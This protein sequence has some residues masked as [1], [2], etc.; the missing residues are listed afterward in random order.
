VSKINKFQQFLVDRIWRKFGT[1][2][3]EFVHLVSSFIN[4][5]KKP[6]AEFVVCVHVFHVFSCFTHWLCVFMSIYYCRLS[7]LGVLFDKQCQW[8]DWL[9]DWQHILSLK[10]WKTTMLW[11]STDS[12][13]KHLVGIYHLLCNWC[14]P[15]LMQLVFTISYVTGVYHL[16]CNWC[17]PSLM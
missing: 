2:G 15:S 12:C 4:S 1:N 13:S 8:I 14:L 10:K 5:V 16:L 7:C 9:T 11:W 17:L 3:G 6:H